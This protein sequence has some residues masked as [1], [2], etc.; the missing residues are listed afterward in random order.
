MLTQICSAFIYNLPVSKTLNL[1]LLRRTRKV[2]KW[3]RERG[4]GRAESVR[5]RDRE[6]E[7]GK[8]GGKENR[9]GQR[10]KQIE[11]ESDHGHA[12]L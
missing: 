2:E 3:E 1:S 11:K 12:L 4:H 9:E 5:E 10:E 8:E 6:R 7:G